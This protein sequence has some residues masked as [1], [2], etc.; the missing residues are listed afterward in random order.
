MLH[1]VVVHI[2]N[3]QPVMVDLIAA[4]SPSDVTVICTNMRT[5]NGKKPVF[6]DN[7]DSTFI[8]PLVHIRFVEVPKAQ[9]EALA[10][11]EKVARP[12]ATARPAPAQ[13]PAEEELEPMPLARLAWITGGG[14]EPYTA[15]ADA[16]AEAPA[17][18]PTLDLWPEDEMHRQAGS[19][20]LDGDLLKRV[21]DV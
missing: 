16:E 15:D 8:I 14:E 1:D 10:A 11:E 2:A 13:A 21:R 12:P 5:M 18:D 4:P 7:A 6:V 3:E 19:A 20:G 9:M 17:D